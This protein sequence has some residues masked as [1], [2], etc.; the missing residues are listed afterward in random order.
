MFMIHRYVIIILVSLSLIGNGGSA[1][2]QQYRMYIGTYTGGASRGIYVARFDASTGKI[3]TPRLAA[4]ATNPSFLAIHPTGKYLY[5]VGENA[6]FA[7]EK[8][9][10]V[11]AYRIDQE[12]ADLHLLNQAKSSGQGPCHLVVDHSGKFVLVAN[13]GG[14]SISAIAIRPDGSLGDRTAFHQHVGSSTNPDRQ[15][16]PHAHSINVD[17]QNRFVFAADLGLD[18]VLIYQLNPQDG[19]LTANDPP[20]AAV[21]PGSG[22]RHFSFHPTGRFA[23]VI[24]ELALTITAFAYDAAKGSLTPVQT[25]STLPVGV[26]GTG[27]STAEVL[28]H[29]SGKFVYGSNRGHDSIAAFRVDPAT[30]RL[31]FIETESTQGKTPRNF[32]IEPTG[33]YLLAENQASDSIVVFAINQDT[34]ELVATGQT[35]KVPS[36]VCIRFLAL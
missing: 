35:L 29:P 19:G 17:S 11:V 13:Y 25:I 21:A 9:G 33:K 14:G 2:A 32:A 30:G 26:T 31:T 23:Y 6:E 10:A 18:K 20:F 5:A 27:L 1:F 24:N 36:P 34:G 22:P 12:S 4:E 15:K 3:G 8:S 28:V 7:G 16:E